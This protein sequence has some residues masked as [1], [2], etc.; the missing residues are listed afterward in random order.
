M[1]SSKPASCKARSDAEQPDL[2]KFLLAAVHS[3]GK[4]QTSSLTVTGSCLMHRLFKFKGNISIL[5]KVFLGKR[6]LFSAQ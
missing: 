2:A 1:K 6:I 3:R 4:V 5:E